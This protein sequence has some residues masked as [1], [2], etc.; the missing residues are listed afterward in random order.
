MQLPRIEIVPS[1]STV[2]GIPIYRYTDTAKNG[3]PFSAAEIAPSIAQADTGEVEETVEHHSPIASVACPGQLQ[4][5]QLAGQAFS[6]GAK[7][8]R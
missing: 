6:G 8:F 4:Q 2:S 7:S 5:L 3:A 1:F